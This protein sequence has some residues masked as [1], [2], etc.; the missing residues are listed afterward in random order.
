MTPISGW[1]ASRLRVT[2]FVLCTIAC[3]LAARPAP[4]AAPVLPFRT[5]TYDE[6]LADAKARDL[7][8]FV[9]SWAPW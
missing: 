6:A 5:V 2:L 7:P 8:L 9:E 1:S 4:A 3:G